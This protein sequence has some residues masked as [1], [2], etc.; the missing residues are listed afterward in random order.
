L[1]TANNGWFLRQESEI[2]TIEPGR[3][4]DLAVLSHD[5]FTVPDEDLK[6]IRSVMT[7]V[8]GRIVHDAG[9]L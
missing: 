7:I 4:A 3:L 8:A 6:R 9:L 2:G 5:Y 1:Y